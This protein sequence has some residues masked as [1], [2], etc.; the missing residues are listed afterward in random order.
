MLSRYLFGPLG[1]GGGGGDD[2]LGAGGER[3]NGL[4][5]FPCSRR[6]GAGG[7]GDG[8]GGGLAM[9]QTSKERAQAAINHVRP[10]AAK[11]ILDLAL[12]RARNQHSASLAL[13]ARMTQASY[14]Q[15]AAAAVSA[16]VAGVS[17]A[18]SLSVSFA[19]ISAIAFVI[20]GVICFRGV[21]SDDHQ[22]PGLPPE[23]WAK[24][25]DTR[26]FGLSEAQCWAAGAIQ[27]MMEE[28]EN[29]N[30]KRAAALNLSL[31][32]AIAGAVTVAIAAAIR[33]LVLG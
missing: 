6:I 7:G 13:D 25:T 32:Y 11:L 16:T 24:V 12:E 29:E 15:F 5:S 14:L 27:E 3:R 26:R 23:W 30:I 18:S 19:S 17:G 1:R 20:G 2:G 21:R 31:R 4:E 8:G 33:G 10:D 28:V 22:A 9:T